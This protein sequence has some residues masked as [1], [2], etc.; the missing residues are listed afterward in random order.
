MR[1]II[2]CNDKFPHGENNQNKQKKT[3][4]YS[5]SQMSQALR[6]NLPCYKLHNTTYR[7]INVI[8]SLNSVSKQVNSGCMC[9]QWSTLNHK[10]P[11]RD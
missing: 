11:N 2:I 7:C 1:Q 10:S 9:Y 5:Q 4:Y 8:N 3:V 6:N